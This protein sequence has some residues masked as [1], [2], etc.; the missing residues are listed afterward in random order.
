MLFSHLVS[1]KESFGVE[2]KETRVFAEFKIL[3]KEKQVGTAHFTG[4]L[5]LKTSLD[6]TTP[7]TLSRRYYFCRH[8]S[9]IFQPFNARKYFLNWHPWSSTTITTIWHLLVGG[10]RV[11]LIPSTGVR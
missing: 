6:T 3:F 5:N 7:F 2:K 8:G 9:R 4:I 11:G 10:L 1:I